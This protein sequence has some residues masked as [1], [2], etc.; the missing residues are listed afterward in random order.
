MAM[1]FRF[2]LVRGHCRS[3]VGAARLVVLMTKPMF[4]CVEGRGLMTLSVSSSY[5]LIM[6]FSVDNKI[7]MLPSPRH[8]KMCIA[9]LFYTS[10][11]GVNAMAI[12][13]TWV[14]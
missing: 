9:P 12:A 4:T 10:V 7:C 13:V 3:E 2:D 8:S 5:V 6:C 11:T 1:I 14:K